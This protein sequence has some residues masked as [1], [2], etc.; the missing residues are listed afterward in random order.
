M[1]THSELGKHTFPTPSAEFAAFSE[2]KHTCG[3]VLAEKVCFYFFVPA[4]PLFG[5]SGCVDRKVPEKEEGVAD[6]ALGSAYF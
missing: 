1:T 2:K 5:S 3:S 4:E 6:A